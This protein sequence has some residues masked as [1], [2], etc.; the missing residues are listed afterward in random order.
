ML[1]VYSFQGICL[2]PR[3][4]GVFEGGLC[5]LALPRGQSPKVVSAPSCGAG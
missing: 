5:Q 4:C 2:E 3:L 1:D